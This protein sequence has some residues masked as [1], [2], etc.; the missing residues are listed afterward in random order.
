MRRK[1]FPTECS[2]I[3]MV[4]RN[5]TMLSSI[6]VHIWIVAPVGY[7]IVIILWT[8]TLSLLGYLK[9]MFDDQIGK[10]IH[11]WKALMLYFENLQKKLKNW[12]NCHFFIFIEKICAKKCPKI[13]KYTFLKSPLPCH[14]IYAK[15][16]AKYCK[17]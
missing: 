17:L 3:L 12:K 6:M 4:H 15:K 8:S 10:I 1:K 14:I 13:I 11:N 7:W 9:T 5:L 2:T 16:I